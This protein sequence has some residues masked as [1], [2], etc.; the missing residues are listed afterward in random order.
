MAGWVQSID[1]DPTGRLMVTA[2][3]DGT[4]RLFD[5]KA[6][7]QL[8]TPLPGLDNLEANAAFTS[9]GT[10][11]VSVYERGTDSST[12]CDQTSGRPV[13]APLRGAR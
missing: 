10:G 6:Q 3:T 8:G 7:A 11:I 9:D 12:T 13:R 5:V 1:F 4:T 2:G